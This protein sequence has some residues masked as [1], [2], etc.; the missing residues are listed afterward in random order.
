MSHLYLSILATF[1]YY[2]GLPNISLSNALLTRDISK[3]DGDRDW[4]IDV[5]FGTDD[6]NGVLQVPIVRDGERRKLL[7]QIVI[8]YATN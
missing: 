7:A 8:Q 1:I 4:L 3:I 6:L 5:I 2:F